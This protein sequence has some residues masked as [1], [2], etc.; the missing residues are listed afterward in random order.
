MATFTGLSVTTTTYASDYYVQTCATTPNYKPTTAG[1]PFSDGSRIDGVVNTDRLVEDGDDT[2]V[3]SYRLYKENQSN[4]YQ[5]MSELE[6]EIQE[7]LQEAKDYTDLEI[8]SA[9]DICNSEAADLANTAETNANTYALNLNTTTVEYINTE[10]SNIINTI[11]PED[12]NTVLAEGEFDSLSGCSYYIIDSKLCYFAFRTN[13]GLQGALPQYFVPRKF[14]HFDD[15]ITRRV[16]RSNNES[17]AIGGSTGT[18]ARFTEFQPIVAIPEYIR[19]ISPAMFQN[20][21][22]WK[23]ESTLFTALAIDRLYI[24][25]LVEISDDADELKLS[26]VR[27]GDEEGY[28]STEGKSYYFPQ[29][30]YLYIS[31][32]S[33]IYRGF[34]NQFDLA[35]AD[36]GYPSRIYFIPS[37]VVSSSI[38]TSQV[39]D[40]VLTSL[41][42][43]IY[44]AT[45]ISNSDLATQFEAATVYTAINETGV[46][47]ISLPM[48]TIREYARLWL[49]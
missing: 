35:M 49:Q 40:V 1:I 13:L 30:H 45:N 18:R 8:L 6:T 16:D 5:G 19:W 9:I 47:E 25:P 32:H 12:W 44:N 39:I 33:Q 28:N 37:P 26:F 38:L 10:I 34:Y 14:V 7:S 29:A 15:G 17:E 22:Y 31:P 20:D 2:K 23:Y 36:E 46:R 24:D 11:L 27:E 42:Q 43:V 4:I 3:P 21:I 48:Q 41:V